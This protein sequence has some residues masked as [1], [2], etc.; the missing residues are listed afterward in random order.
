MPT[1]DFECQGCGEVTEI[2][3]RSGED[4]IR[5]AQCG[6]TDL[7]RLISAPA[8]VTRGGSRSGSSSSS[9]ARRSCSGCTSSCSKP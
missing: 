1:Y 2:F 9:C 8:I 3:V 5:C 6:G 7:D 4:S